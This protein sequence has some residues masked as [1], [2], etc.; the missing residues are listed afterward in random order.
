MAYADSA[1]DYKYEIDEIRVA[2]QY[3]RVRYYTADSYDGRPDLYRNFEVLAS[4]LDST[5]IHNIIQEDV[6]GIVTIWDKYLEASAI[7]SDSLDHLVGVEFTDRYKV[8]YHEGTRAFNT[9]N[10]QK[11][12]Q[13]EYDSEG[14]D[15]ITSKWSLVEM[16]NDEKLAVRASSTFNTLALRQA[17]NIED[18]LDSVEAL[19]GFDS[20]SGSLNERLNWTFAR[21]VTLTDSAIERVQGILGYND[22]AFVDWARAYNGDSLI[23]DV[24]RPGNP[25]VEY[26]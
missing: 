1:L 16:T 17:L 23:G 15:D 24:I 25:L 18:R 13:V 19:L 5:S 8:R 9:Y 12:K 22:S 26:M 2:D 20:G 3:M 11:F 7:D 6:V 4:E 21:Q 14:P 10:W